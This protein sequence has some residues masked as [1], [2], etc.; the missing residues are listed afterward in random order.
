MCTR[1]RKIMSLGSKA[2]RCLGLTTLPPSVSRLSIQRGILNISHLDRAPQPVTGI[3]LLFTLLSSMLRRV[4]KVP[5]I[6]QTHRQ[7]SSRTCGSRNNFCTALTKRRVSR[8]DP[9]LRHVGSA[10]VVAVTCF[11]LSW[12]FLIPPTVP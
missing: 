11:R 1:S 12:P 10:M 7:Q 9:R 4:E 8:F 3:A 6:T 5:C 2:R